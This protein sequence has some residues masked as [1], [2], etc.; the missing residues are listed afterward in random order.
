VA[1][2]DEDTGEFVSRPDFGK[3]LTPCPVMYVARKHVVRYMQHVVMSHRKKSMLSYA[4]WAGPSV[5]CA[6]PACM[7]T[8]S[9]VLGFRVRPFLA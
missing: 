7:H 9:G 6:H 4:V 8:S 2:V 5:R 1:V 3:W